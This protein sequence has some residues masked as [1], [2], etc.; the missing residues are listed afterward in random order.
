MY[1]DVLNG[2]VARYV[3][4]FDYN[5]FDVIGKRINHE[6]SE[7]PVDVVLADFGEDSLG[8]KD[9]NIELKTVR[10]DIPI[11]SWHPVKNDLKREKS[12][13]KLSE[14]LSEYGTTQLAYIR[15]GYVTDDFLREGLEGDIYFEDETVFQDEE[16]KTVLEEIFGETFSQ[17]NKISEIEI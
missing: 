7:T 10:T 5:S 14:K 3:H 13:E 4:N 17:L 1:W 15:R 9:W 16:V 8:N 6:Y 2:D 11:P 12:A